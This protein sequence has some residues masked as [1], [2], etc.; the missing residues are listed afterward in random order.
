MFTIGDQVDHSHPN[1]QYAAQRHIITLVRHVITQMH[2]V[3]TQVVTCHHLSVSHHHPRGD[4]SLPHLASL[5][6]GDYLAAILPVH[7]ALDDLAN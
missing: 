2:H 4:M 3:S 5:A 1:R 6:F 7:M